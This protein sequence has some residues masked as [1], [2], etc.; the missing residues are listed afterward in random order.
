[1][2]KLVV[3]SCAKLQQIAPQPVWADVLAERPDGLLLLG[4]TIYLDDDRHTEPAALAAELRRLF[5]AQLA[6]P[7]F[8]ALLADMPARAAPVLAF[9]VVRDFRGHNGCGVA[10][11]PAPGGARRAELLRAFPAERVEGE[12]YARRDFGL[13]EVLLLDVRFHRRS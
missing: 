4:D 2:T 6:E 1:M 12:A 10:C 3:A 7:N 9:S 8:S 5:D 11:P 13:V